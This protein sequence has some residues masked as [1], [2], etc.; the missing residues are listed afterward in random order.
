MLERFEDEIALDLGDGAADE[1]ARDLLGAAS[2][3]WATEEALRS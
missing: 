2:A 1:R 3:A